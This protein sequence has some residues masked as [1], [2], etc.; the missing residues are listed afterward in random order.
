[1]SFLDAKAFLLELLE[2]SVDGV[3]AIDTQ[4]TILVWNAALETMFGKPRANAVGQPLFDAL[5]FLAETGGDWSIRESL[6]GKT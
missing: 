2:H 6:I 4:G 1:M 3:L 5:E